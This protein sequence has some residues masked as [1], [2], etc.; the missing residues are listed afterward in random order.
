[1]TQRSGGQGAVGAVGSLLTRVGIARGEGPRTQISGPADS[2]VSAPVPSASPVSAGASMG[3]DSV[4]TGYKRRNKG[5]FSFNI[6]GGSASSGSGL[7]IPQ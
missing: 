5:R 2:P 6:G 7:N 3:T 1:M 4:S